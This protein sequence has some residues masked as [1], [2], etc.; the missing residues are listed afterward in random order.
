MVVAQLIVGVKIVQ[1]LISTVQ[2]L[3]EGK[4]LPET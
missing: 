3:R 1:L 2:L 4:R